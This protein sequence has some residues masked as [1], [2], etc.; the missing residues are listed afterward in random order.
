M[1]N[2]YVR[3]INIKEGDEGYYHIYYNDNKEEEI[4]STSINV[5]DKVS[6]I[7]IIIDYQVESFFKTNRFNTITIVKQSTK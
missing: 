5:N 7:N 2:K 1:V 3:F 6:K 4:K